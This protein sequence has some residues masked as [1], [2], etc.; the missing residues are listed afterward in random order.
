MLIIFS[1]LVSAGAAGACGMQDSWKRPL[2]GEPIAWEG[3]NVTG[4]VALQVFNLSID[5]GQSGINR[6]KEY[7]PVNVSALES[8]LDSYPDS[9]NIR[10]TFPGSLVGSG[11]Y[12]ETVLVERRGQLGFAMLNSRGWIRGYLGIEFLTSAYNGIQF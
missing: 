10:A 8:Y 3:G 12:M 11:E 2:T 7:T 4:E 9:I 5:G 1:L 6:N